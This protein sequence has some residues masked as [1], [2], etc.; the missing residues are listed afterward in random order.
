MSTYE[1][2]K[3]GGFFY[4]SSSNLSRHHGKLSDLVS[5]GGSIDTCL[6]CRG[7]Y[8]KSQVPLRPS[9]L[10]P[11][12]PLFPLPHNPKIPRSSVYTPGTPARNSKPPCIV[13]PPQSLTPTLARL[14][15]LSTAVVENALDGS[16]WHFFY[17]DR[18]IGMGSFSCVP[19]LD[20]ATISRRNGAF[21]HSAFPWSMDHLKYVISGVTDVTTFLGVRRPGLISW[22]RMI[23][24]RF[25]R[26][27]VRRHP[28][29]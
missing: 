7:M 13:S 8:I 1:K 3:I 6:S 21:T 22:M 25:D 28:A 26:W 20:L 2:S 27:P 24:T 11:C 18:R 16:C 17:V 9:S 23:P 19:G 10:S 15:F 12:P 5:S 14:G 4:L 29:R